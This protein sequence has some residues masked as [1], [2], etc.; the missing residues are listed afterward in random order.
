MV[1]GGRLVTLG[2]LNWSS[3]YPGS[4]NQQLLQVQVPPTKPAPNNYIYELP[5]IQASVTNMDSL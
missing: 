5:N 3:A 1:Y 4:G 2:L